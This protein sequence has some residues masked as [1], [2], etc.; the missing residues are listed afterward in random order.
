M[1]GE[2][3]EIKGEFHDVLVVSE[4]RGGFP[5]VAIANDID[6]AGLVAGDDNPVF[7]TIPVGKANVRSGN[8]RFYDEAWLAELER[9][10]LERRPVG[11]M[12]HLSEAERGHAMPVEA[13]HWLG[14]LR[15]GDTLWAK[16]YLPPGEARARIQRYKSQGKKLAT[17]I[18]CYAE[19]VW[20]AEID[21]YRM[22]AKTMKLGQ[23]D[24]APA[25][26]AGLP[27]LAAVPVLT[28][29]MQ[30]ED[31]DLTTTEEVSVNKEEVIQELRAAR[32]KLLH[33]WTLGNADAPGGGAAAQHGAAELTAIREAL[34]LDANADVA[35]AITEMQRERAAAAKA[36]VLS[37]ITELATTGKDAVKVESVRGVVIE[38]VQARGPQTVE[39]AERIYG[40][41]VAT[42]NVKRLLQAQVREIMG[43]AQGTAVALQAKSK[44]NQWWDDAPAENGNGR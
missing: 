17:S 30:D 24:I 34:G 16:G 1:P 5:N 21:A 20:D 25:D 32:P 22:D 40:E 6:F 33:G 28:S 44:S 43:P 26:R 38:L 29:E 13:V 19:G 8:K 2:V 7:L 14:T 31:P 4:L 10:T 27:D 37:R 39:D 42:D 41:V 23:I 11:L 3:T 35:A 15:E 12:G 36:A 18:D 9:Q